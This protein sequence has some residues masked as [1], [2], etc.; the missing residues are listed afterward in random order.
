MSIISFIRLDHWQNLFPSQCN[1]KILIV[2][3]PGAEKEISHH[4]D[5]E[6]SSRHFFT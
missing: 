4:I 5:N 2:Q 3:T 1:Q 6:V